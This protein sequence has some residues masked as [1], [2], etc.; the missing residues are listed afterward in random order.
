MPRRRGDRCPLAMLPRSARRPRSTARASRASSS[1]S[2]SPASWA[3]SGG[4]LRAGVPRRRH[5]QEHLRHGQLHAAQHGQEIVGSTHGLLRR[6]ATT[7]GRETGLRPRGF[8][9]RHRLARPVAARQPRA[10][11]G[12]EGGGDARPRSTAAPLQSGLLGLFRHLAPDARW[13]PRRLT[14]YVNKGHIARAALEA[15]AFQT[16]EVSRR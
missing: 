16:R 13:G 12:R 14:R 5:G 1:T 15:T 8:D 3:T 9:R 11:Q 10:H 2:R 6:S 4:D 7:R